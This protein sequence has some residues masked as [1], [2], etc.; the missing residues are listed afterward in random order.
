MSST[1][2]LT[3]QELMLVQNAEWLL[4]KQQITGKVYEL[5]GTLS[6]R[7]S[8]LLLQYPPADAAILQ[9]TPKIA[10]GE[11]YRQLPYVILDQ[12][13]FFKQEDAFA[14]R[15]LFW[16]GQHFSI[17]LHLSGRYKAQYMPLLLRHLQQGRLQQWHTVLA[18]DPWQHYFGPGNYQPVTPQTTDISTAWQT[19]PFIKLGQY[20]PLNRWEKA[21]PFYTS[22]FETLLQLLHT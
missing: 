9:P 4:T 6:T 5:L 20:L 11:Y 7:Y 19:L 21:L 15:S 16:W 12:P 1:W 18:E 22:R 13:R 3:A 2:Q 10:R 8:N 14:I 17:H